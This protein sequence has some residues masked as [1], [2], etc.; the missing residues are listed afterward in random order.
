MR[1]L[2]QIVI[3]CASLAFMTNASAQQGIRLNQYPIVLDPQPNDAFYLDKH[4]GGTNYV[5]R[6]V[7]VQG[8]QNRIGVNL[9]S[10]NITT[11]TITA[12]NNGTIGSIVL[13]TNQI[14]TTSPLDLIFRVGNFNRWRIRNTWG[15]LEPNVHELYDIGTNNMRVRKVYSKDGDF[16]GEVTAPTGT[17]VTLYIPGNGYVNALIVT[18]TATIGNIQATTGHIGLLNG[19]T[20]RVN[21]MV[22]T[23]QLNVIGTIAFSSATGTQVPQITAEDGIVK[24]SSGTAGNPGKI[25]FGFAGP[26]ITTGSGSPEGAVEAPSGSIYLRTGSGATTS[27]YVKTSDAPPGNTGWVAK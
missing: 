11:G 22:V 6:R 24:I 14:G 7:T 23:N 3:V 9:L 10:T 27:F 5:P 20:N 17:Y 15:T 13:N 19:G 18:N 26:T 1:N 8:L 12:T 25:G 16:S 4:T 2:L 21:R